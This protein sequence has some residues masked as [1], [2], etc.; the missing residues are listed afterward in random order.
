MINIE[1]YRV[2]TQ[3]G[4]MPFHGVSLALFKSAHD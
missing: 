2:P 4:F 3:H 1:H